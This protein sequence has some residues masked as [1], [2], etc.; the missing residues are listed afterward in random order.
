LSGPA[1]APIPPSTDAPLPD[2]PGD[3]S[4]PPPSDSGGTV[5]PQGTGEIG[6]LVFECRDESNPLLAERT[7]KDVAE[8]AISTATGITTYTARIG[9]GR[10]HHVRVGI[11]TDDIFPWAMRDWE[12][13]VLVTNV[14]TGVASQIEISWTEFLP[15]TGATGR[16]HSGRN[17]HSEEEVS[18]LVRANPGD[19]IELKIIQV[20]G[21]AFDVTVGPRD[22]HRV[23]L[24]QKRLG[25]WAFTVPASLPPQ[26]P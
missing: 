1:L 15:Y 7:E 20:T 12:A 21:R 6:A 25:A 11:V 24:P 5:P 14:T 23:V 18:K 19:R 2:D 9:N 16:A 8:A 3:G 4:L 13:Q 26:V 10:S 17:R 22:T